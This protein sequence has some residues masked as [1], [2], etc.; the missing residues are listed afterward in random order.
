[1]IVNLRIGSW[2]ILCLPEVSQLGVAGS[3]YAVTEQPIIGAVEVKVTTQA[4]H[5]PTK[6]AKCFYI[7]LSFP[8][9]DSEQILA[10]WS[11]YITAYGGCRV[12][13]AGQTYIRESPR[14]RQETA[15]T[16]NLGQK[17][18]ILP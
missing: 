16:V 14:Y 1:M 3:Q 7:S 12:R 4:V 17:K 2:G 18:K 13:G 8:D 6:K 10:G 5:L 15:L 11:G 9:P